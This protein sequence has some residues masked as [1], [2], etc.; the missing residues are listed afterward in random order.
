MKYLMMIE[1]HRQHWPEFE[2]EYEAR[3]LE[4]S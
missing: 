1:L 3:P 2:G 4:D